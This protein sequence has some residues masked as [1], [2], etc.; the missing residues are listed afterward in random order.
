ML[1]HVHFQYNGM[2]LGVLLISIACIVRGADGA[3]SSI[4]QQQQQQQ[5]PPPQPEQMKDIIM[6]NN[7]ININ[8][9]NYQQFWELLAAATFATLLALKHL[10]LTLAPLYFFY[11]LRRHCFIITNG[12]SGRYELNGNHHNKNSIGS[13]LSGKNNTIGVE[14]VLRFSL[15]RL[16]VLG[17]VTLLCFLG[18][19]IPF[20]VQSVNPVEQIQ[21][22]V[23]RLFPFGRG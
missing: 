5:Q 8:N 2:L 14:M 1:D 10:Y 22:I 16:L 11:L 3:S 4:V 15:K 9:S 20:M 6:L 23:K 19:F 13:I 18:P 7:N 21:Q 12:G 17:F